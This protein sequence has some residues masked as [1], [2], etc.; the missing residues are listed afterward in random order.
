MNVKKWI[1]F[2]AW[3]AILFTGVPLEAGTFQALPP[4]SDTA[5]YG[6]VHL[7]KAGEI[8]RRIGNSLFLQSLSGFLDNPALAWL[9]K[10]PVQS[11]SLS[12]GRDEKG[13]ALQGALSFREDKKAL[14]EKLARGEGEEGDLDYLLDFPLSP[15]YFLVP[16]DETTYGVIHQGMALVLLSVEKDLLLV[17]FSPEDLI[18][19]REA[20]EDPAKRISLSRLLEEETFFRFHDDGSLGEA[21]REGSAGLFGEPTQALTFELGLSFSEKGWNLSGRSNVAQAYPLPEG[22]KRWSP[23]APEEK[24]LLGGGSPLLV[25]M[26]KIPLDAGALKALR[27][28]AAGGDE[29]A[30][31]A[32]GILEELAAMGVDDETLLGVLQTL[33]L[34]IGGKSRAMGISVPGAHLYLSGEEGAFEKLVP[35]VQGIVQE[36]GL[37]FDSP[38]MPSWNPLFSLSDPWDVTVG[39]RKGFLLLGSLSVESLGEAPEKNLSLEALLGRED[40]TGLLHLDGKELRKTL[41]LLLDPQGPWVPLI[42]ESGFAEM[43]PLVLQGLQA[44]A[45][46][47]YLELALAGLDRL[48]ITLATVEPDPEEMA[49]HEELTARWAELAFSASPEEEA[50]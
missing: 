50:P 31:S 40:L 23:M 45:E 11:L 46:M 1:F 34:V 18:S 14:L 35:L 20:L 49:R 9:E 17:G 43:V 27:E 47:R 13:F 4:R 5:I 44:S 28:A 6:V 25:A 8:C 39:F 19:C 2:V 32:A 41:E 10:M 24:V 29:N 22:E 30:A 3:G 15:D 48:E 42:R 26:G 21:L 37:S 33:G 16:F 7:E 38:E 36:S 12:F